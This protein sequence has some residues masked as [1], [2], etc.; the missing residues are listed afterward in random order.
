MGKKFL[1]DTNILID[2]QTRNIPQKGFE[3]VVQAIDDSFNVS[4]ISYIEFVGYKNVT[5][6]MESFIALAD[7][8]EINKNIIN[9]TV[10]I[11][12]THQIK[13]PDAI[14]AATAIIYDL[15]LVSHNN[16]DFKNIKK[17]HIVDPYK[18][19]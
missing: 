4:F 12:K 8:I 19:E 5:L 7:V 11:R 3:Y 16:K 9:Q 15:I 14:I 6:A 17:L 13:L 10:L 1:I 2:F 18:F